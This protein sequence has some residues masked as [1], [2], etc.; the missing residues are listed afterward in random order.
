MQEFE[1]IEFVKEEDGNKLYVNGERVDIS[2]CKSINIKVAEDGN[3]FEV[4]TEKR[5]CFLCNG[6]LEKKG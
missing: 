2:D 3:H 1:R 5:V 6:T 4:T